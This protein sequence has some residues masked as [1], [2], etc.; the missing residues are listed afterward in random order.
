M[1]KELSYEALM[2]QGDAMVS[3]MKQHLQD[4]QNRYGYQ[5]HTG[6]QMCNSGLGLF[7]RWILHELLAKLYLKYNR[8]VTFMRVYELT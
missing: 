7:L 8:I 2:E 5:G 6:N 1:L 3:I 4:E